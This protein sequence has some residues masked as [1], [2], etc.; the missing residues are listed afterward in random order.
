MSFTLDNDQGT[1]V[2]KLYFAR[3]K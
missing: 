3:K 1:Y 2:H